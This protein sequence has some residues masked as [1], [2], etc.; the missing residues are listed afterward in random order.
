[1]SR[2][3]KQKTQRTIMM[4]AGQ[5]A[6][7]YQMGRE[8]YDHDPVF[9]AAMDRCD[10][11]AGLIGGRK[12]SEIVYARPM[13]E[14]DRFD[15]QQESTAALLAVS[16]SLAQVLLDRRV[17]PHLLLGYS[18]GEIIA[19]TVAG[20][21]SIEAAFDLLAR[22]ARIYQAKLRPAMLVTVIESPAALQKMPQ[23]SAFCE[24]AAINAPRHFTIAL[25]PESMS[26]VSRTLEEH[27]IAWAKLPVQYGF[28]SSFI[29]PAESAFRALQL[30]SSRGVIPI[31][32]CTICAPIAEFNMDHLWSVTRKPV[33]FQK[34]L[35]Q[36]AAE[37]PACFI[38]ASPSGTLAALVRQNLPFGSV[39][40]PAIKQSGHDLKT[41][42]QVESVFQ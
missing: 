37:G 41:I 14:S 12:I 18:L 8:L 23:V 39:A 2:E 26:A 36:V 9:R 17:R 15:D 11:A 32:S 5:G 1:M 28:H 33:L 31:M 29:D 4:F 30:S 10:A 25:S 13:L 42:A 40:L 35:G 21:L 20:V 16:Y 24:L 19:A 3:G 27:A 38:D 22:L 7:Y 34:T 6:Q